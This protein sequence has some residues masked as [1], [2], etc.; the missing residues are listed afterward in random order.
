[1]MSETGMIATNA[2]D[3]G[4]R[5]AGS[6][7]GARCRLAARL[8]GGEPDDELGLA[9]GDESELTSP[10][11]APIAASLS[12]EHA[13]LHLLDANPGPLGSGTL[14][15]QLDGLGYRV[16]EPTVG[17]YL[18]ALDRRALTAR[19]SNKGRGLTDGGRQRLQQLCDADAQLFYERELVRT[20]R[21]TTVEE[22]VDVLVARRALEGETAR[23]AAERATD[24]DVARLEAVIREQRRALETGAVA[25]DADVTFHALIAQA[26]HNRVLA[27]AIDLIR[28]DKQ[29]TL[30]LDAM[31]RRT[32]HKWVVGHEAILAAIKARAPDDAQRAMLEHINTVIADVRRYRG[33]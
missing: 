7:P 19:V 30:L 2:I 23:L 20:I 29:M 21:S 22:V 13:I 8:Q 14:M 4:R 27:A 3:L 26:G 33:P 18:R 28:G 11:G 25:A 6:L 16:S 1:M 12:F 17:R 15:E 24:E 31:L 5:G 9:A 10:S 32:T